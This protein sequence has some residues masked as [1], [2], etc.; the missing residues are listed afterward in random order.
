MRISNAEAPA[1]T[2]AE[3]EQV[4]WLS[5]IVYLLLA[6]TFLT[7]GLVGIILPGLP[8]TPFILLTSYFLSRSSPRLRRRLLESKL[9]GSFLKDWQKHRGI[10]RAVKWRAIVFVV[11]AVGVS[12]WFSRLSAVLL[13]T[14]LIAACIGIAIVVS[15]PVI[16]PETD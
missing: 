14:I 10:R 5:R 16:D 11:I 3:V 4:G 2:R 12:C 7:L 13:A 15:L 9:F 1:P 8:T 6:G